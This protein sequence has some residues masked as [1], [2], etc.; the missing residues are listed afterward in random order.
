MRTTV[1]LEPDVAIALERLRKRRHAKMK[2][3][4]NETLRLGLTKADAPPA[5]KA[6][7][8]IVPLDLGAP[9][10]PLDDVGELLAQMDE[11][12]DRAKL[13]LE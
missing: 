6:P 5:A 13:G 9:L 3:V 2:D 11:A 10:V 1:T 12:A 8:R 4:I 7:F